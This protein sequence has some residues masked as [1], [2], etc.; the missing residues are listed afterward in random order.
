M[1]PKRGKKAASAAPTAPTGPPLDGCRVALSGTFPGFSQP[2]LQKQITGLGGLTS[3]S[4]T[5]DT[6]H[7]ITVQAD[8]DKPSTKVKAAK[9]QGIHIVSLPWLQDCLSSGSKEDETKYLFNAPS[10]S[11]ASATAAVTTSAA[12]AAAAVTTSS[13]S[14]AQS[15]PPVSQPNG[16][17]SSQPR[18]KRPRKRAASPSPTASALSAVSAPPAKKK[19]GAASAAN[20]TDDAKS[21]AP[22]SKPERVLGEGQIAKSRDIRVP[23]DDGCPFVT[24]GV[25]ID[26]QGV[27]YDA[28][29]NQTNASNNNNK[30]YRIQVC[31]ASPPSTPSA[32]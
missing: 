12:S 30:F 29:L 19:K 1:P 7:L 11:A 17:P 28:S 6:T 31:H 20:G 2:A 32:I 27:I 18:A 25:Y 22:K 26:D 3:S 23:L 5:K 13:A 21:E 14:Q 15:A 16:S 10:T 9:G 4:I 8:Y 24:Y